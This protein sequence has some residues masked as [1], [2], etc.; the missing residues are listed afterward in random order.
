MIP[1]PFPVSGLDLGLFWWHKD[2]LSGQVFPRITVQ[3]VPLMVKAPPH[4]SNS[5]T[6]LCGLYKCGETILLYFMNSVLFLNSKWN[7]IYIYFWIKIN[8]VFTNSN[9]LFSLYL[10]A[11]PRTQ[12]HSEIKS[13][14]LTAVV[15]PCLRPSLHHRYKSALIIGCL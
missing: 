8:Q 7:Y 14:I 10:K 3:E 1:I 6:L 11:L 15:D 9:A 4:L 13:F 2:S 5:N 12:A